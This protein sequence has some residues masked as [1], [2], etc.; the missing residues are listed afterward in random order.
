MAA[1]WRIAAT[2]GVTT[3]E[4]AAPLLHWC[5]GRRCNGWTTCRSGLTGSGGSQNNGENRRFSNLPGREPSPAPRRSTPPANCRT[6][7]VGPRAGRAPRPNPPS[8]TRRNLCRVRRGRAAIRLAAPPPAA[9]SNRAASA[10]PKA[11]AGI[12][13]GHHR[14]PGS[15]LPPRPRPYAPM[16]ETISPHPGDDPPPWP[17]T[18]ETFVLPFISPAPPRHCARR[19]STSACPVEC[20]L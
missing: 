2:R 18:V 12:D 1:G 7:R 11:R 8:I 13:V 17:V 14:D 6:T 20:S 9:S 5:L 4:S 10:T 19:R 15:I 16:P 3:I